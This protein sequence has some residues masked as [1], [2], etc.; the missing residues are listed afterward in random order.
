MDF[1]PIIHQY[2]WIIDYGCTPQN[3]VSGQTMDHMYSGGPI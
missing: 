1:I 3:D 2:S